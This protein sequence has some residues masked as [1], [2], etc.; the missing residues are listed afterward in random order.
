MQQKTRN[1]I[2]ESTACRSFSGRI[3]PE[4]LQIEEVSRANE[5]RALQNHSSRHGI[6]VES[7][8]DDSGKGARQIARSA[9]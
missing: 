2:G 6:E 7:G 9:A 5:R 1:T 4:A 8:H 3:A